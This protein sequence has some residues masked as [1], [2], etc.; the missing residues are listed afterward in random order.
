MVI[1][2]KMVLLIMKIHLLWI[3]LILLILQFQDIVVNIYYYPLDKKSK[4]INIIIL[5]LK[6]KF[7]MNG[8]LE[9]L[10]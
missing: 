1:M 7:H 2:M 3:L 4:I 9:L 10:I 5:K 6:N 8:Y